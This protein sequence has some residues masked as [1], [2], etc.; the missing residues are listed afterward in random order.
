MSQCILPDHDLSLSQIARLRKRV[1]EGT[2]LM[3]RQKPHGF[4]LGT[5]CGNE[6]CIA[7]AHLKL[8]PW[9]VWGRTNQGRRGMKR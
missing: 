9:A 8:V 1:Y 3:L 4:K 6:Q 5:H 7:A 2:G